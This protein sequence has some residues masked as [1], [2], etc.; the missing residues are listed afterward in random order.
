MNF[1]TVTVSRVDGNETDLSSVHGRSRP[2][3]CDTMP[4]AR[5]LTMMR[6]VTDSEFQSL[7][8]ASQT[9]LGILLCCHNVED[10]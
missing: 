3:C 10:S 6:S 8:N 9:V 5:G 2:V 1:T 7:G 4:V